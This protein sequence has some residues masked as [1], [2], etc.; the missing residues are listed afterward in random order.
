MELR[1]I[2]Q[3]IKVENFTDQRG[4][5]DVAE[6]QF[7]YEF[8]TKRVYYISGVPK[9]HSRGAH[10]HKELMQIFFAIAGKFELTVTDGSVSET[11]QLRAHDEGYFLPAGYWRELK[12]FSE[13]AICLVLASEYYNKDD[14]IDSYNEYLN[15]KNNG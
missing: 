7:G 14:Y 6:I 15:W 2:L 13:D 9:D 10:A 3:A 11:V 8:Q 5:L 12:H 4:G 1:K